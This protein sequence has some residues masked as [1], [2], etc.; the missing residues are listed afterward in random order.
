M[1]TSSR[2]KSTILLIAA[3][4]HVHAVLLTQAVAQTVA[5]TALPTGGTVRAGAAAIVQGGTATNPNL[6]INQSTNR[7]AIDWSTFNIGSGAAVQF[8]QPDATSSTLNRVLDTNASQIFGKL[9]SNG[10]VFLINPNGVVFGA[11]ASVDVG[12]LVA[13][14]HALS[15][16]DYMAGKTTFDRNGATGKITNDGKLTSRLGGYIALLAPEVRNTGVIV[17]RAGTVALAA[18]D[19]IALNFDHDARLTNVLA[20]PST[21]QALIDNKKIVAAP[22]GQV[23]VSA[24]AYN[25]LTDAAINNSGTISAGSI[26]K[27]GGKIFLDTSGILTNSGTIKA[28]SKV[29]D[30]G[31]V[32]LKAK[33]VNNTGTV[34]ANGGTA[35]VTNGVVTDASVTGKG[36]TVTLLGDQV[37]LF[38]GSFV[39]AVGMT[40]GGTVLVGG[41]WQGGNGVPQ[42][43]HVL[44]TP[45]AKID[46]S[47]LYQGNGGK[48]VLWST[49]WTGFY[50]SIKATGGAHSGDGGRVETSSH[51]VLDAVGTLDLT[52]SNGKGGEWLLDPGDLH[53]TGDLTQNNYT[54]T[55]GSITM[56]DPNAL[57]RVP[58]STINS[59][60]DAGT[61]VTLTTLGWLIINSTATITKTATNSA[62]LTFNAGDDSNG[63]GGFRIDGNITSSKSLPVTINATSWVLPNGTGNINTAV[64]KITIN[65]SGTG[66][67]DGII[68]GTSNVEVMGGGTL[69]FLATNTYSGTTTISDPGTNL[70]VGL[71]TYSGGGATGTLGTGNV[72]LNDPTA[73]FKYLRSDTSTIANSFSGSGGIV[74]GDGSSAPI[75]TFTGTN[76][77]AGSTWIQSGTLKAGSASAFSSSSKYS[78]NVNNST[79][80]VLDLGTAS[81]SI[82]M[83][84]GGSNGTVKLGA[85]TLT[86]AGLGT[87][88]G[89]DRT[90][91]GA[92]QGTG[93]LIVSGTASNKQILSGTN[94]F[95]GGL[96]VNGGTLVITGSTATV[97]SITTGS[98]GTLQW[99]DGTTNGTLASIAI[100]DNGTLAYY[101][102]NATT[103]S[104]NIT[105]TGGLVV[106][107]GG[108][109]NT[110]AL[111]LTGTNT[112]SGDITVNPYATLQFGNLGATGYANSSTGALVVNGTVTFSHVGATVAVDRVISGTGT[113]TDVGSA[114]VQVNAVNTFTGALN[115]APPT[116]VISTFVIGSAASFPASTIYTSNVSGSQFGKIQ[117]N[118]TSNSI[119][120]GNISGAGQMDFSSSAYTLTG[121]NTGYTGLYLLQANS[122][123]LAGA[124]NAINSNVKVSLNSASA[125]LNLN[126]F[127]ST[128]GYLSG[129]TGS[130]VV[131]GSNTLTTGGAN[132]TT[133]FSGVIS[134]AGNL[135]QTGSATLTLTGA[136]TYTGTTT[137]NSGSTLQIGSAG[138]TGSLASSQIIDNGTLIFNRTDSALTISSALSGAGTVTQNGAGGKTTLT[139]TNSATGA[140]NVLAGTLVL[141]GTNT[142]AGTITINSGNTLQIGDGTTDGSLGTGIISNSGILSYRNNGSL[143]LSQNISG[144]GTLV[145]GA[146]GVSNTG[147]LIITG[148]AVISG[149]ITINSGATLQLGNGVAAGSLS[150]TTTNNGTLVYNR[151][152]SSTWSQAISG[153]SGN[154]TVNAGYLTLSGTNTYGGTTTIASGATLQLGTATTGTLGTG[155]VVDNGILN[156]N[157]TNALT[158]SNLISGTGSVAQRGTGTTTLTGNNTFSGYLSVTGGTLIVTGT[159][160]SVSSVTIASTKILQIGDGVT[161]GSV[162]TS[163]TPITDYGT[164]NFNMAPGGTTTLGSVISN[165][166]SLTVTQGTLILTGAN[167]YSGTTTISAGTTLQINDGGSLGASSVTN[168]GSLIFANTIAS[169]VTVTGAISG[170]G[171]IS[172]TDAGTTTLS[173]DNT[174]SG[175]I[176][177]TAGTLVLSGSNSTTAAVD[178]PPL[179]GPFVML[180]H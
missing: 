135:V 29:A 105:G 58:A 127:D 126:G 39:S 144:L 113:V 140:Y 159:N 177:V 77:Y 108:A 122:S 46:A 103:L 35:G 6:T 27:S 151:T 169:S 14:T 132:S 56:T 137:I 78:F 84:D 111:T 12:G 80:G 67:Y 102:T 54:I 109:T 149:G 22:D 17:A 85:N 69:T 13:T 138:T 60:L 37:G 120:A 70:V 117:Y 131:L 30:G 51:G 81:Q 172:Q 179:S 100:T 125:V 141:A 34:S 53:V 142:A 33:Q 156:I 162:G 107:N 20:S 160:A 134:G 87:S 92:I 176:G 89:I 93:S 124:A 155:P 163:A 96:T 19:K 171:T 64:G 157:H 88:A 136:N 94:T 74:I 118:K 48:V 61:S 175:T 91:A 154:L 90:F 101:N 32:S 52:A 133:T 43:R 16:D 24:Q 110:V 130:S 25:E 123:V 71:S 164:L 150:G 79:A 114:P 21:V 146:S 40:G 5:P 116:S 44:V 72:I 82:G 42:A 174:D 26:K 178:Q 66:Q 148:A 170:T 49:E 161:S 38:D 106:G 65:I 153:A 15:N 45:N 23:I 7:A 152:G 63:G 55:G 99:G 167:T 165:V 95:T 75:V 112:F 11:S 1:V 76:T 68:S 147:T 145:V 10:Q 28:N 9:T 18:G 139:G 31:T 41:D 3:C 98:G 128:I 59:M 166:G 47:A 143:I 36:G 86:I 180:V 104:Q 62:T 158:I 4:S 83:L 50:G 129:P 57:S 2:F 97:T 8:N 115:V 121:N 119:I 173:G 168:N 73:Q